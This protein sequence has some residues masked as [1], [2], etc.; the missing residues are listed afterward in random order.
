MRGE[1]RGAAHS[2]GA[3]RPPL[4]QKLAS[5]DIRQ[6]AHLVNGYFVQAFQPLWLRD[7]VVNHDGV[8][9]LHVGDADKLV[10]GGV[11]ALVAL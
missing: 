10:D 5:T 2:G 9:V 4:F 3:Y 1:K 8:D 11:V 6:D 7:A